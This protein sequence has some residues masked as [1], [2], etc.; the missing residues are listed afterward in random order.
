MQLW[1]VCLGDTGLAR[2][3]VPV[4]ALNQHFHDIVTGISNMR[5]AVQTGAGLGVINCGVDK[6]DLAYTLISVYILIY[7]GVYQY[8]PRLMYLRG[9]EVTNHE[10][11]GEHEHLHT[12][13]CH[14]GIFLAINVNVVEVGRIRS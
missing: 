10:R 7:T 3:D 4:H 14:L 1:K 8:I 12:I 5:Q 11:Q 13:T 6:F 9:D 2:G